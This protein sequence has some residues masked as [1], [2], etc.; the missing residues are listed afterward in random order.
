MPDPGGGEYSPSIADAI[1]DGDSCKGLS[2]VFGSHGPYE[3]TVHDHP[4][5]TRDQL[6]LVGDGEG[7]QSV[8]NAIPAGVV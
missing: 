5:G 3:F 4:I 2:C 1:A 7:S 8:A 6:E